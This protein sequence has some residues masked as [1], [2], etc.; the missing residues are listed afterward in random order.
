MSSLSN[1]LISFQ[2]IDPNKKQKLKNRPKKPS[3][4]AIIEPIISQER[5]HTGSLP[6]V[7]KNRSESKNSKNLSKIKNVITVPTKEPLSPKDLP[8][9]IN[10]W[11]PSRKTSGPSNL[12]A[13]NIILKNKNESSQDKRLNSP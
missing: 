5:T 1:K 7:N 6:K 2:V 12:N 13:K 3:I 8:K 10:D 11:I 9:A 4:E